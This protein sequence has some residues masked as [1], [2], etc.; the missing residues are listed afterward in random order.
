[1]PIKIFG[2]ILMDF[3]K[4]D[5]LK[6]EFVVEGSFYK[7]D[8]NN[9]EFQ[10]RN[11]AWIYRYDYKSQEKFDALFVLVNPGQCMPKRST[12]VIP[13]VP[14]DQIPVTYTLAKTDNTQYQIMRCMKLKTWKNVLL[15]NLSDLRAGNMAEFRQKL[16]LAENNKF[17]NHSIF[18][19]VR[20]QELNSILSKLK[21]PIILAWGTD[22]VIRK[23]AERAI[24]CL[25]KDNIIGMEHDR[26]PY[27]YHAS[28]P[29]LKGKVKW[30]EYM[31]R[32]V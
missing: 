6:N 30:L 10:C 7:V 19:P 3:V 8:V 25:P 26:K 5:I 20:R 15:I 23:L 22:P 12:S 24:Q 27:Y 18:S 9:T 31:R 28:P 29:P 32:L 4:V 14:V 13:Q 2:G 21:G 11:F 17:V 1:M 16:K